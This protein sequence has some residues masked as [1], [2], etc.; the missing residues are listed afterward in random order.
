MFQKGLSIATTITA[1]RLVLNSQPVAGMRR[2]SHIWEAILRL[3]FIDDHIDDMR[4]RLLVKRG[5]MR[6]NT[7]CSAN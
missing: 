7:F 3:L 2:V 4:L 5:Q 1:Y 6:Y